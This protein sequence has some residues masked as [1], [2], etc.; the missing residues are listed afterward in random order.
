MVGLGLLLLA[1]AGPIILLTGGLML[2]VHKPHLAVA[3]NAS[4]VAV[5][6]DYWHLLPPDELLNTYSW[7]LYS[8]NAECPSG[9]AHV[10][11]RRDDVKY[12]GLPGT[13][14]SNSRCFDDAQKLNE[15]GQH[16][17]WD[18]TSCMDSEGV[19]TCTNP[20]PQIRAWYQPDDCEKEWTL[21]DPKD[22][23]P[24]FIA[25]TVTGAALTLIGCGA[26]CINW[27]FHECPS[28]EYDYY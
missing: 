15:P 4:L 2:A 13:R 5:Q 8:L 19:V 26:M 28:D 14:V 22:T 17:T 16:E 3:G 12:N 7:C 21:N 11:A 20:R 18:P 23:L 25:I 9:S 24:R 27:C 1:I 10:W 6:N